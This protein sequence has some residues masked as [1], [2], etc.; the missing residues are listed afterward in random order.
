MTPPEQLAPPATRSPC[1]SLSPGDALCLQIFNSSR[2]SSSRPSPSRAPT[3][4]S[5][6]TRTTRS[7][8]NSLSLQLSLPATRSACRSPTPA[9]HLPADHLPAEL[10]PAEMT[11]PNQ[12]AL[13]PLDLSLKALT[14]PKPLECL[15]GTT[16]GSATRSATTATSAPVSTY[17]SSAPAS[18]RSRSLGRTPCS[19]G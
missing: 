1:N 11:P 4:K 8:C 9:D 10:Q 7:P 6:S 17:R 12:P 15:D 5:D 19:P 13:P 18:T 2:P 16:T 3:Y 14:I